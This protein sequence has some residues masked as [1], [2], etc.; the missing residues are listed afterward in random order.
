TVSYSCKFNLDRMPKK[1]VLDLGPVADAAAVSVNGKKA[2]KRLWEP[3][4]L[5]ITEFAETGGNLVEIE[6]RNTPIN[7]LSGKASPFGLKS[8]PLV[9]IYR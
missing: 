8:T 6:T 1:V 4:K 5:D 2:G 7:L 9:E 3:Y